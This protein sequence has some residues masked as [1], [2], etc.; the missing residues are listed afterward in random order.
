MKRVQNEYITAREA[1]KILGVTHKKTLSRYT[2]Q[3][4]IRF[5]DNGKGYPKTYNLEDIERIANSERRKLKMSYKLVPEKEERKEIVPTQEI[6]YQPEIKKEEEEK[7]VGFLDDDPLN[8]TGRKHFEYLR[9][10]LI[11]DGTYQDKDVGLLQSYCISYQKY[12]HS[13]NQSNADLDTTIDSFGNVKISPHFLIA[14]K[15]L[16]QMSKIAG[17]LGIGAK[18]RVGLPIKEEKKESVFDILTKDDEF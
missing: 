15:C 2:K 14:D 17:I 7:K 3:Y 8:E 16:I 1:I 13:V 4:N 6:H 18:S 10:E 12:I 9:N 5:I 11:K